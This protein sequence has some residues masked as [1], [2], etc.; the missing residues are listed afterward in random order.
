MD[1]SFVYFSSFFNGDQISDSATHIVYTHT[2]Y[3]VQL[4]NSA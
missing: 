4:P 1:L 3:H 2:V